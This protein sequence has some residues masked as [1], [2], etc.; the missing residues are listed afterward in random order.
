MLFKC[1]SEEVVEWKFDDGDLPS[2]AFPEIENTGLYVLEILNVQHENSGN[3]S[4][5]GTLQH[6]YFESTG[7]L[8]VK[9]ISIGWR[10][11]WYSM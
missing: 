7:Q 3:Y 4:C 6:E 5:L 9:G 2:N 8:K 1:Q 11:L 10:S